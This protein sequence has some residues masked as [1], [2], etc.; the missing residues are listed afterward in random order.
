[1]KI[2][3]VKGVSRR[4]RREN[5]VAATSSMSAD[6]PWTPVAARYD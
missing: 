1:M 5:S 3:C 4:M 6:T 2:S